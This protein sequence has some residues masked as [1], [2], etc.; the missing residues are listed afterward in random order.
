[1]NR[2]QQHTKKRSIGTARVLMMQRVDDMMVYNKEKVDFW[3]MFI[4]TNKHMFIF[5]A[6]ASIRKHWK[7]IVLTYFSQSDALN[8][9]AGTEHFIRCEYKKSIYLFKNIHHNF[10][11]EQSS[12]QS[13][14]IRIRT[15]NNRNRLING[16]VATPHVAMSSP[17]EWQILFS[18]V[19]AAREN[20][21][22]K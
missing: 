11:I 2:Q 17:I 8:M 1:M 14:P 10:H 3:F 16:C 9:C 18:L 12:A 7:M 13:V 4:I 19:C 21:V 15:R 22:N 5:L 6:L 20:E